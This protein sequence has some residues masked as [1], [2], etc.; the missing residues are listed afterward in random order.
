MVTF[1]CALKCHLLF[2]PSIVIIVISYLL[3]CLYYYMDYLLEWAKLFWL[4]SSLYSQRL[5][6]DIGVVSTSKEHALV[7]VIV[8]T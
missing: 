6:K 2:Q 5:G 7:V 3:E 1:L 4:S 8:A